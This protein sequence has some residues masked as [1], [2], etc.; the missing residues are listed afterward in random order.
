MDD[1]AETGKHFKVKGIVVLPTGQPAAFAAIDTDGFQ[2]MLT[3][4]C[5]HFITGFARRLISRHRAGNS[6]IVFV[7]LSFG[8]DIKFAE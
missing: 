2:W 8:L 5:L 6:S 4:F 1:H 7:F 3:D